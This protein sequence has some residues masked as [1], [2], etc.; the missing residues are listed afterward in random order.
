MLIQCQWFQ[1]D[2]LVGAG[3]GSV[4]VE[5]LSSVNGFNTMN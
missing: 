4:A 5:G 3:I 2:E 1:S